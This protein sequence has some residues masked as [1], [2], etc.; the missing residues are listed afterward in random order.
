MEVGYEQGT[1]CAVTE[2][3]IEELAE[4]NPSLFK[5]PS[6]EINIPRCLMY[7]GFD[8]RTDII[9]S[10][11]DKYGHHNKFNYSWV[12]NMYIRSTQY[13][14]KAYRCTVYRG[15][16]R[17]AANTAG[18]KDKHGNVPAL[19]PKKLHHLE[20]LY[21]RVGILQATDL[22]KFI[23]IEELEDLDDKKWEKN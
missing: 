11:K 7:L 8:V 5:S 13:P 20:D 12:D 22:G 19:N 15:W 2:H 3:F 10:G 17:K 21:K 6:G 9:V 23:P 18:V 1:H 16:L 4:S 14:T